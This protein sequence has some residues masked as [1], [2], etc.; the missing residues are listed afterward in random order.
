MGRL[1]VKYS[2]IFEALLVLKGVF[3]IGAGEGK[4]SGWFRRWQKRGWTGKRKDIGL[5]QDKEYT[6][7]TCYFVYEFPMHDKC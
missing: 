6:V 3:I 4:G 5:L 1:T 7:A 2:V